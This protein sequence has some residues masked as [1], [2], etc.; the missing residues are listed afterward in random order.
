MVTIPPTYSEL[1]NEL[2][3]VTFTVPAIFVL[4]ELPPTVNRPDPIL[5]SLATASVEFNVVAPVTP[6]VAPIVAVLRT[7][8]FPSTV[9]LPADT[10]LPVALYTVN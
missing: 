4:P 6:S 10:K 5:K 9:P 7:V 1:V 2:A 3:P 8:R